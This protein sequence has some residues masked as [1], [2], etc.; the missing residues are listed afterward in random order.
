MA[1][2]DNFRAIKAALNRLTGVAPSGEAFSGLKD[3]KRITGEHDFAATPRCSR[4]LA[5]LEMTQDFPAVLGKCL[6]TPLVAGTVLLKQRYFSWIADGNGGVIHKQTVP[7]PPFPPLGTLPGDIL[8]RP[9]I[10][11]ANVMAK[12]SLTPQAIIEGALRTLTDSQKMASHP[13]SGDGVSW[14][15]NPADYPPERYQQYEKAFGSGSLYAV[16]DADSGIRVWPKPDNAAEHPTDCACWTCFRERQAA[17]IMDRAFSNLPGPETDLTEKALDNL[18]DQLRLFT[19]RPPITTYQDCEIV[20]GFDMTGRTPGPMHTGLSFRIAGG[21][22]GPWHR[23]D[24]HR[25][26]PAN[27]EACDLGT[28][29]LVV[30]ERKLWPEGGTTFYRGDA[31]FQIKRDEELGLTIQ[32]LR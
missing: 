19:A 8:K 10:L 13:P 26:L 23:V 32:A 14:P 25:P 18:L 4:C 5:N 28:E 1:I 3:A 29:G 9:E 15:F 22:Y 20:F 6:G 27:Y 2:V 17:H 11:A 24:L 30:F 7:A 16:T 31:L 12:P 21:G